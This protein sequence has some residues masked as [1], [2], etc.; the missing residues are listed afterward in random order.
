MRPRLV[1]L[2][3]AAL[4]MGPLT[5]RAA[6]SG[7]EPSA[8]PLPIGAVAPPAPAAPDPWVAGV[9]LGFGTGL[10][11]TAGGRAALFA[12]RWRRREPS[13]RLGLLLLPNPVEIDGAMVRRNVFAGRLELCS[14]ALG[15]ARL[16]WRGCGAAD[17]GT[18]VTSWGEDRRETRSALS[19][20]A[21]ALHARLRQ[22]LGRSWG[23]E[24]EVGGLFPLSRYALVNQ[25]VEAQRDSAGLSLALGLAHRFD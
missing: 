6:A 4:V 1:H 10:A 22:W 12:E 16:E 7:I 15:S 11:P 13:L 24:G 17:V 18:V 3:F 5:G 9:Q 21:V 23:V 20:G 14:P 25:G 19:W 2:A 8:P